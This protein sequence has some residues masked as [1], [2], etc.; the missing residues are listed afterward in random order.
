ML[1]PGRGGVF[2]LR[3]AYPLKKGRAVRIK[4]SELVPRPEDGKFIDSYRCH[5]CCPARLAQGIH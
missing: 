2:P 3:T 4:N 5:F 1:G